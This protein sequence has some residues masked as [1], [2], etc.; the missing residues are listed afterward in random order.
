MDQLSCNPR[1]AVKAKVRC[2]SHIETAT[3]DTAE[4]PV[5]AIL[6]LIG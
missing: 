4:E 2:A 3:T 6:P 5:R 1:P